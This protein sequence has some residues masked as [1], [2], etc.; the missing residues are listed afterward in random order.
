[1]AEVERRALWL[2]HEQIG[3]LKSLTLAR[4]HRVAKLA[5]KWTVRMRCA[6]SDEGKHIARSRSDVYHAELAMLEAAWKDLSAA[7]G[8]T[9]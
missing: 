6:I 8:A 1:V 4:M 2:T 9:S 7:Y 5:D 3:K